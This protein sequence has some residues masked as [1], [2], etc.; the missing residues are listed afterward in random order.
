MENLKEQIQELQKIIDTYDNIVFF[1]GAGVQPANV[2]RARDTNINDSNRVYSRAYHLP[3][4]NISS[5]RM[6]PFVSLTS[7]TESLRML[8]ISAGLN[9]KQ[10]ATACASRF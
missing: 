7:R 3:L 2:F 10:S 4:F 1:G 8:S 9:S 5:V 6:V